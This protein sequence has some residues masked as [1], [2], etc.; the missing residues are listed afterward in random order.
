[1]TRTEA[2][3]INKKDYICNKY[4]FEN[5]NNRYK[6]ISGYGRGKKIFNLKSFLYLSY[7]I[8]VDCEL[9]ECSEED[10]YLGHF[11]KKSLVYIGIELISYFKDNYFENT[12]YC[13]SL[14]DIDHALSVAK[15]GLRITQYR[16]RL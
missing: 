3:E 14:P 10:N 4:F 9:F 13:I 5:S 12:E 11:A 2:E 1:M 15:N 16:M 6:I 8:S 7:M